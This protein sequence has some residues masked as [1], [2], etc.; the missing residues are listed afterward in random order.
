METIAVTDLVIDKIKTKPDIIINTQLQQI[1][2]IDN[3]ILINKLEYYG[4]PGQ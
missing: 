1:Q 3:K 4:A 2:T